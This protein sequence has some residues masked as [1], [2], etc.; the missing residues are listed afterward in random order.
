MPASR[1]CTKC[2]AALS[3]AVRWCGRC[4]QPVRE[5]TARAPLHQGDFVGDPRPVTRMTRRGGDETSFGLIGRVV[6]TAVVASGFLALVAFT[7]AA[8]MI[9]LVPTAVIPGGVLCAW[10]LKETWRAVP[11]DGTVYRA[12]VKLADIAEAVRPPSFRSM[13]PGRRVVVLAAIA[14]CAVFV[15]AYSQLHHDAQVGVAMF[16]GLLGVGLLAAIVLRR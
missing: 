9:F 12:P 2:G 13:T 3:G 10:I 11:A 14:G 15:V 1:N 5:F 7:V 6:V 8:Q 4:Y 16:A